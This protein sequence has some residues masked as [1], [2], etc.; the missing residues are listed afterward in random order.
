MLCRECKISLIEDFKHAVLVCPRCGVVSPGIQ[1]TLMQNVE[2]TD[3]VNYSKV[4]EGSS[5]RIQQVNELVDLYLTNISSLKLI[6]TQG[7]LEQI[8]YDVVGVI[9]TQ[10]EQRSLALPKNNYVIAA[11]GM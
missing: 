9:L 7:R 6:D 2:Y 1:G 11:V 10:A 3:R 8:V 4:R 5:R